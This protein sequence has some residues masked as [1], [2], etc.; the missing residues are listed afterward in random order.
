MNIKFTKRY[1]HKDRYGVITYPTGATLPVTES[2][3]IGAARAGAT[4]DPV[5]LELAKSAPRKKTRSSALSKMSKED[6]AAELKAAREAVKS[7]DALKAELE[8]SQSEFKELSVK[9]A[10]NAQGLDTYAQN[11]AAI[12]K[13]FNEQS[14]S[15][16]KSL[17]EMI[18][19]MQKLGKAK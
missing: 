7:R 4:D 17:T 19:A 3:A 14:G 2:I 15:N 8:K 18:A 10:E 6:M 9:A 12:V 16:V 1:N 11:E 13:L 5:A